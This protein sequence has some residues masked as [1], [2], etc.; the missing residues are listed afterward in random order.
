MAL[1]DA[2]VLGS[3]SWP[4]VGKLEMTWT[5]THPNHPDNGRTYRP[6]VPATIAPLSYRPDP[7]TATLL[8]EATHQMARFDERHGRHAATMLRAES[9]ASSR[10][11]GIIASTEDV[12]AAELGIDTGLPAAAVVDDVNATEHSLGDADGFSSQTILDSHR[13]LM[14]HADPRH[15]RGAWRT[16]AV[17]I[18]GHS[19]VGAHFVPPHATWIEEV[20]PDLDAYLRRIDQPALVHAAIAHAQFETIH[21]FTDGNGRTGRA[22]TQ[23]LF[24]RAGVTEHLAV[25]ISAGLTRHTDDYYR[26]LTAYRH[27]DVEPI[28]QVTAEAALTAVHHG[29]ELVRE[30]EQIT[31]DWAGR[32]SARRDAAVWA[33]LDLLAL[34]PVLTP[35]LLQDRLGLEP[36][37]Q[38]RA[39]GPLEDAGIITAHEQHRR[40][41]SWRAHELLAAADTYLLRAAQRFG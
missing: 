24:R 14:A 28:L 1:P 13:L 10:I 37:R 15:P 7:A 35:G 21:P 36:R 2:N 34:H 27:G 33:V 9:I 8:D 19:P 23:A 25:P 31:A 39:M 17:W 12:A 29:H 4:R 26:A 32:I 11:E 16:Q 30:I 38:A 22:L 5:S 3:G 18:G 40:D 41:R 20:L 6:A